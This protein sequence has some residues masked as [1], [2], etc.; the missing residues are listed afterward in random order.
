ML[1]AHEHDGHMHW[2]LVGKV[3]ITEED[4]TTM[5]EGMNFSMTVSRNSEFAYVADPIAQHVLKVHI[6]D[7]EIEGDLE[8]TFAPSA[9]TWLGIAEESD[10]HDH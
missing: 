7:L 1:E 4:V 5:P 2:E 10:D 8:L 3:D 9:I 6:E